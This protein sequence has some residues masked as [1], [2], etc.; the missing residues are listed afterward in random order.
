MA[1]LAGLLKRLSV[2]GESRIEEP[3]GGGFVTGEGG[4]GGGGQFLIAAFRGGPVLAEVTVFESGREQ[5]HG[6]FSCIGIGGNA[7]GRRGTWALDQDGSEGTPRPTY[8][9]RR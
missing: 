3:G 8:Q 1:N 6:A 4:E 7:G 2:A 9:S 5:L